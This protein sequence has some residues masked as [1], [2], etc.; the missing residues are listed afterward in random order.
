MCRRK[1]CVSA[2]RVFTADRVIRF[3]TRCQICRVVHTSSLCC[4][5]LSGICTSLEFLTWALGRVDFVVVGHVR[6]LRRL[7]VHPASALR[8]LLFDQLLSPI[9]RCPFLKT[10]PGFVEH[11]GKVEPEKV[12]W[13]AYSYKSIVVISVEEPWKVFIIKT[14]AKDELGRIRK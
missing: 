8:L 9:R 4:R 7:L 10:L 5:K 2:N 12:L 13:K 3:P 14:L 11:L 1:W 6:H